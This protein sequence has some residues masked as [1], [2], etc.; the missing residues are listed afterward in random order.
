MAVVLV[1]EDEEQ[2]RVL[3][4]LAAPGTRP[5]DAVSQHP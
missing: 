2:V 1:V 3:A 4:E 5:Q